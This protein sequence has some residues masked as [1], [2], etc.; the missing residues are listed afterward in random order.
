LKSRIDIR[1]PLLKNLNQFTGLTSIVSGEE[2]ERVAGIAT[3]TC[4]TYTMN[5]I[6]NVCREII[7]DNKL[8]ILDI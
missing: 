1:G 7:I 8:D 3:T 4:T 6:F 2:G 5:I